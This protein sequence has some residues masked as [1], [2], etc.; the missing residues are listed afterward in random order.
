MEM[1]TLQEHGLIALVLLFL[2][3]V[4]VVLM[5][6]TRHY[7]EGNGLAKYSPVAEIMTALILL[8]TLLSIYRQIVHIQAQNELQR[9]V[10]SKSAIQDLNKVILKD[11]NNDFLP[12]LFPN[13]RDTNNPNYEKEKKEARETM[14][15][16][17]LMN[18]LEMLYLT[19]DKK[20]REDKE[21][22]DKFK[23]LLNGFTHECPRYM[24]G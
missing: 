19:Q 13:L 15:A 24:E 2:V 11:E 17:S 22:R 1:N 7:G 16:F 8:F 10:A 3:V 9:N 18:S 21:S 5:F 20:R 23:C 14:M 12:F 4:F 6:M